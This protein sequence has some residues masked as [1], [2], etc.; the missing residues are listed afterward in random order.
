[1]FEDYSSPNSHRLREFEPPKLPV[2]KATTPRDEQWLKSKSP[3]PRIVIENRAKAWILSGLQSFV[4][5]EMEQSKQGT[6]GGNG[7]QISTCQIQIELHQQLEAVNA[8]TP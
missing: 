5:I 2:E 3:T 1:M 6:Y 7:K 4:Q 8:Q